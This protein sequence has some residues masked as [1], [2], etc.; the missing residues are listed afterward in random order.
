MSLLLIWAGIYAGGVIL[1][2]IELTIKE[3]GKK[4]S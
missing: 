4:L 3:S 2:A 1:H